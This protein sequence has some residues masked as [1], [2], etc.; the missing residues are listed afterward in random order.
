M[1]LNGSTLRDIGMGGRFRAMGLPAKAPTTNVMGP[2]LTGQARTL[3]DWEPHRRI[4]PPEEAAA[5][6]AACKEVAPLAATYLQAWIKTGNHVA[7][8][9]ILG[10]S[11][12][13]AR[14]WRSRNPS[15]QALFD[16]YTPEITERWLTVAQQKG[17]EGFRDWT[18]DAEGQLKGS[19]LREDPGFLRA[20]L[21]AIDP[22]RWGR[23]ERSPSIV[24]N[25]LQAVE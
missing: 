9:E 8:S 12:S 13:A 14:Y 16:A 2:R 10:I 1:N 18:F 3:A 22:E 23:D 11:P 21:G 4:I 6:E 7:A 25:V 20:L 24:V 17:V 15:Y 19:R 5:I